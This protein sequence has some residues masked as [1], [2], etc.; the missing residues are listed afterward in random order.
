M[1]VSDLAHEPTLY[2]DGHAIVENYRLLRK[3]V[4]HDVGAVIKASTYGLH[5]TQVFEPLAREGCRDFFVAS[6]GEALDYRPLLPAGTTLYV[7]NT[8]SAA[9]MIQCGAQLGIVPIISSAQ[10]A[11]DWTAMGQPIQALHIDT[12]MNRYGLSA[13]EFLALCAQHD[14]DQALVMSQLVESEVPGSALTAQ[15]I[16]SFKRLTANLG[17]RTSLA[18][19]SGC[20]VAEAASGLARPG[21]ALY[22]GNPTPGRD[23]PMRCVAQISA[24]LRQKRRINAG[25]S[26]GYG[27]SWTASA[28]SW[29]GTLSVGYADGLFRSG[30]GQALVL[31]EAGQAFPIVGK[32]SMDSCVI[33][34]GDC[35]PQLDQPMYLLGQDPRISLEA[36]AQRA[37]TIG[38]E[39][40]T[41]LGQRYHRVYEGPQ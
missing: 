28:D 32:I 18:N 19:S 23:N 8:L 36:V 6:L 11:M 7:L 38:Y 34:F 33:D 29:L 17:C 2:I 12:G 14:L 39:V 10:Q 3:Q 24:R 26:V 9:Q 13:S 40:L 1:T 20:F 5:A 4:G 22:G 16:D 30:S 31:D 41:S 21:Y 27:A 15:Q 37:G 35:E 25:E